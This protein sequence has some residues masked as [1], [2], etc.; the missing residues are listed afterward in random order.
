MYAIFY[1]E[2]DNDL[3]EFVLFK[4]REDA[5]TY[6]DRECKDIKGDYVIQFVPVIDDAKKHLDEK[7][8][9]E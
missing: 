1:S 3:A 7:Y 2:I 6:A 5:Q 9:K 8:T 4:T